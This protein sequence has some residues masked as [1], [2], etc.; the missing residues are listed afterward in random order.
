MK[1]K[2]RQ[3][4]LDK[5]GA[6]CQSQRM[7]W[8]ATSST[9]HIFFCWDHFFSNKTGQLKVM[10]L[11]WDNSKFGYFPMLEA[12]QDCIKGKKNA[13]VLLQVIV[14]GTGEMFN[15]TAEVKYTKTSFYIEVDLSFDKEKGHYIGT[16][17][18]I[19]RVV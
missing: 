8:H 2:P 6:V 11:A 14:E 7:S 17:T 3:W 12:I 18:D 16:R 19:I 9:H 10:D 15:N 5:I 13:G 1:H 4:L